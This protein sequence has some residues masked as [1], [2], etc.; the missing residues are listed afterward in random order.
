MCIVHVFS[1]SGRSNWQAP[2]FCVTSSPSWGIGSASTPA[3]APLR[4]V[5]KHTDVTLTFKN[6]QVELCMPMQK[7]TPVW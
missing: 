5:Y 1:N 7:H 3:Q 6:A 2:M 4:R